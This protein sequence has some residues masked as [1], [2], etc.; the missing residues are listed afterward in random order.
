MFSAPR[1][2]IYVADMEIMHSLHQPPV[3]D[4]VSDCVL[5]DSH[6]EG[7]LSQSDHLEAALGMFWFPACSHASATLPI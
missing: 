6:P 3:T 7:E 5:A 4:P 1:K 2:A